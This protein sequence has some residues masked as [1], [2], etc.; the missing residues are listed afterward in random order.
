[1]ILCP[2][3]LEC[4]SRPECAGGECQ[5]CGERMSP[6]CAQCGFVIVLQAGCVECAVVEAC[7]PPE[8]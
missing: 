6:P 2:V 8:A 5:Q 7:R 1:M 3:E 4:C